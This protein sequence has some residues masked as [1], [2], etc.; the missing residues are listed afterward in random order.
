MGHPPSPD[1]FLPNAASQH[2]DRSS[3]NPCLM[4]QREVSR[5]ARGGG[6]G[7]TEVTVTTSRPHPTEKNVT[8]LPLT[9]QRLDGEGRRTPVY[10]RQMKTQG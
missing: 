5:V 3:Q 8:W 1:I 2:G 6:G 10:R 4:E 7:C 9:L